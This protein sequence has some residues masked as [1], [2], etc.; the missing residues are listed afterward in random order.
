MTEMH[1]IKQNTQLSKGF[2]DRNTF[3]T[4]LLSGFGCMC[5]SS[6]ISLS[7]RFWV[8]CLAILTTSCSLHHWCIIALFTSVYVQ[9]L[10]P[11]TIIHRYIYMRD[12]G[13]Y[14]WLCTNHMNFL[15]SIN[16]NI[17]NACTAWQFIIK[18]SPEKIQNS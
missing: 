6:S 17:N 4:N 7:H 18:S 13:P 12:S 2:N 10:A 11:V 5:W 15:C 16:K 3:R 9:F 14:T 8:M 1:A